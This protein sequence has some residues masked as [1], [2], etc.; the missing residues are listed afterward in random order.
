ML[1][2]FYK[3][4]YYASLAGSPRWRSSTVEQP[5]CKR[6]VGGSIPFASSML[7]LWHF[8]LFGQNSW[9]RFEL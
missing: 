6:L 8:Q 4:W 3:N 7:R 9:L 2:F 5:P 1:D